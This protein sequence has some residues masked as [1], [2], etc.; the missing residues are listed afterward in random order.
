MKELA[1]KTTEKMIM[2]IALE[3]QAKRLG[4]SERYDP[5]LKEIIKDFVTSLQ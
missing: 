1:K 5:D 3:A 2:E 4:L